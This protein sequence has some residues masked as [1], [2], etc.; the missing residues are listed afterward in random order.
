MQAPGA[1]SQLLEALQRFCPES[2]R[3]L[4][5]HSLALE[6]QQWKEPK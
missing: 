5:G 6:L 3:R 2:V 1:G 4:V